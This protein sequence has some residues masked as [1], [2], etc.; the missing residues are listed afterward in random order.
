MVVTHGKAEK[1]HCLFS[2]TAQ[3]VLFRVQQSHTH[4][5]DTTEHSA[6]HHSS[7]YKPDAIKP[8]SAFFLWCFFFFLFLF[9]HL[10]E[11]MKKRIVA[12]MDQ[13]I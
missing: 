10:F 9:I 7:R 6:S 2:E 1:M 4:S 11:I 12:K 13:T 3:E 5:I 8:W